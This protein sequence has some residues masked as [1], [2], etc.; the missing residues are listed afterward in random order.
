MA[1]GGVEVAGAEQDGEDR[2]QQRHI[3][4]GV[5][6]GAERL[7]LVRHA[8]RRV[9]PEDQKAAGHRLELQG[10]IGDHADHRDQR[11]QAA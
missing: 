1:L 7:A 9:L 8:D 5:L 10:D 2:Q 4:R 3:E 11:D 6:Q